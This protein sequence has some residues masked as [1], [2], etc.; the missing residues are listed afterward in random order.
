MRF[1][2]AQL[3]RAAGD[4]ASTLFMLLVMVAPVGPARYMPYIV[5]TFA[6]LVVVYAARGAQPHSRTSMLLIPSRSCPART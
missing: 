4:H 3:H 2:V 5:S 6:V 1:A